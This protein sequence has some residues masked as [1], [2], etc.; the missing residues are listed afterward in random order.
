MNHA[1]CAAQRCQAQHDG[2]ESRLFLPSGA[3]SGDIEGWALVGHT[4]PTH[5]AVGRAQAVG[6]APADGR[7]L[8]DGRTPAD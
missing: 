6:R 4:R 2:F 3:F 5:R 7:A 1:V 8:A